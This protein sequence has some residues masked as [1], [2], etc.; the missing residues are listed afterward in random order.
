MA[1]GAVQSQTAPRNQKVRCDL[2]RAGPATC[3][4]RD[5]DGTTAAT[6]PATSAARNGLRVQLRKASDLHD[7][8]PNTCFENQFT[9]FDPSPWDIRGEPG[10][11]GGDEGEHAIRGL[12]ATRQGLSENCQITVITAKAGFSGMFSPE[13]IQK[14]LDRRVHFVKAPTFRD[15]VP[16]YR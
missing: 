11:S 7:Y 1:H 12:T 4:A 5:D 9:Y 8:S 15:R 2:A 16:R 13:A 3:T 6:S 14:L 10:A